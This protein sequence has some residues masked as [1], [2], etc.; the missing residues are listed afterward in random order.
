M[1]KLKDCSNNSIIKR[2][3]MLR[4]IFFNEIVEY[5]FK[6]KYNVKNKGRLRMYKILSFESDPVIQSRVD[7]LILYELKNYLNN[8]GDFDRIKKPAAPL[9]EFPDFPITQEETELVDVPAVITELSGPVKA[10]LEGL[11]IFAGPMLGYSSK[12]YYQIF[13]SVEYNVPAK[14]AVMGEIWEDCNITENEKRILN[15]E[16]RH[17]NKYIF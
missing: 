2:N 17:C 12:D 3:K 9:P 5:S 1:L 6:E 4:C 7:K 15:R 14:V 8:P 10:D 11:L 16:G 13:T